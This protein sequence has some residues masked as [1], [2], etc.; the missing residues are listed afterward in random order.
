MK[1]TYEERMK[2]MTWEEYEAFEEEMLKAFLEEE[3]EE[4]ERMKEMT[5][6]EYEASE[7]EERKTKAVAEKYNIE[8]DTI[9]WYDFYGA[10]E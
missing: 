4:E 10:D 3:T 5:W 1:K 2:E 9:C 6:E 7:A 8:Y